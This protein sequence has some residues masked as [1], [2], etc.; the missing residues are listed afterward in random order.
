MVAH[1]K[2]DLCRNSS[3]FLVFIIHFGLLHLI[4][5]EQKVTGVL[6]YHL[7]VVCAQKSTFEAKCARVQA[8]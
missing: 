6:N 1:L 4:E 2:R 5:P 3:E 7:G 8:S